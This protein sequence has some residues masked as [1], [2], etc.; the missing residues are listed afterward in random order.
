MRFEELDSGGFRIYGGA[1]DLPNGR[2]TA[3][4]C[5][6]A[7]REARRPVAVFQDYRLAG[8]HAFDSGEAA[9]RFA[10]HAGQQAVRRLAQQ[11]ERMSAGAL[12]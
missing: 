2:Y 5:V 10:T 6:M 9:L 7:V 3:A 8:G 12:A 4:V 1:L 11:G